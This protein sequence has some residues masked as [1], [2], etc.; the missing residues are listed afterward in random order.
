MRKIFKKISAIAVTTVMAASLFACGGGSG[1][2]GEG[3]NS[4]RELDTEAVVNFALGAAWDT[5]NYYSS[6]G[7]SYAY[8]VADKI[9]DKPPSFPAPIP[10]LRYATKP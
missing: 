3:G 10:L 5:L 4:G 6:T 1:S 9:F 8:L 2:E 7:G